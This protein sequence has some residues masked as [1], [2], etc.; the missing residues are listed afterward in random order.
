MCGES[1]PGL[2]GHLARTE[3]PR[4][5]FRLTRADRRI[6]RLVMTVFETPDLTGVDEVSGAELAPR[7]GEQPR[8]GLHVHRELV[9]FQLFL[10]SNKPDVVSR[11]QFLRGIVI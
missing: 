4:C 3:L 8:L 10:T 5:A 11:P 1:F 6:P 9:T 7:V 2:D